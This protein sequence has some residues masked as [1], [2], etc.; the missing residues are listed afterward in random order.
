V[1]T[2]VV[3]LSDLAFL[4]NEDLA[5]H[6]DLGAKIIR[7]FSFLQG[8]L[9]VTISDG[10]AHIEYSPAAPENLAEALRL[11]D[12]G[13]KAAKKGDFHSALDFY[14]AALQ[15]N[16]ALPD[17][18][19]ELAMV[20]Y[21]LGQ[22]D[23]A[24]DELIDALRLAPDDA[25]SHLVMG[26]I[27]TREKDWPSAIRFFSKA[28]ELKPGDPYALNGLGAVC[29]KRGDLAKAIEFFD[30]AI[31]AEPQMLEPQ[32][33]KAMALEDLG[34]LEQCADVLTSM[35]STQKSSPIIAHAKKLL[36]RVESA[37]RERGG[38]TNPELLQEK[39]PAAV[40]HLLDAL[41]RFENLDARRVAEITFEV[42]RL[43]EKGLDYSSPEQKYRLTAY[44]EESFSG[45]QLM[46]LMYA[47]FKRIAPDQ[48]TGMDLNEPW[49][50]ALGL[51][52]AG[53]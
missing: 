9:K 38:P 20:H 7:Q 39:H 15:A 27:F 31:Q 51:F 47:G 40:W 22:L 34:K 33:G 42:A 50:S 14:T 3:K 45:L 36:A 48:D 16:P 19:R 1:H 13:A 52:N 35:I 21:E 32:F 18:R 25:W 8:D 11:A 29:A 30:A 23:A 6:G 17:T 37:I 43:G 49:L 10:L 46:C 2:F 12:Q 41:K 4:S 44:P 24:K 53:R 5:A 28:I 26:N